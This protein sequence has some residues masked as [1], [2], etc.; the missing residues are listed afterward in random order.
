MIKERTLKDL[1]EEYNLDLTGAVEK[2]KEENAKLVLVQFP[3]GLKQYAT[4]IVDYLEEKT[5]AEFLI[6]LGSC[7]GACDYP[8]GMDKLGIDLTIQFG[9][10]SLMP[11]YLN[12]RKGFKLEGNE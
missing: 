9:H 6:F 10:S 2:I 12:D 4:A 7:F 3:D 1:E 8:V 11:D 5:S